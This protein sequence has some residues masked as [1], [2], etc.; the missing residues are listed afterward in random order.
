RVSPKHESRRE[1]LRQRLHGILLRHHQDR[2]RNDRIPKQSPGP[3]RHRQLPRLLQP[4]P[5]AF[6]PEL[7]HSS[8]FRDSTQ[9]FNL[10]NSTVR[11]LPSSSHLLKTYELSYTDTRRLQPFARPATPNSV[12]ARC[13]DVR[14]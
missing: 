10:S 4:H 13:G 3:P 12:K 1:L 6:L 5:P 8:R 9:R 2:T 11:T 14:F 7:P